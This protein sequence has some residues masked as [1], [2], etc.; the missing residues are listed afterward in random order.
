MNKFLNI[1]IGSVI[2]I[3]TL[4][5]VNLSFGSL[6]TGGRS[7]SGYDYN[8]AN[9]LDGSSTTIGA[10]STPSILPTLVLESN[11]SR[12]GAIIT[13]DSDTIIYL[14]LEDFDSATAASTTVALNKGIR[15]N[16]SGGSYTINS[17]NLYS[18]DIYATSTASGKNIS[19]IEFE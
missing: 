17:Q 18:G 3:G 6:V 16:A 14:H 1:F 2:V 13:N 7:S 15:L 12:K 4:S 10:T 5:L 11:D 19:Y 9:Q 8:S